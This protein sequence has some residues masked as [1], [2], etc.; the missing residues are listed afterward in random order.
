MLPRL[1]KIENKISDKLEEH[2]F[3]TENEVLKNKYKID[4]T[5]RKIKVHFYAKG[6]DKKFDEMKRKKVRF[7]EKIKEIFIE[8]VET[9]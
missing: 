2:K 9:N 5:K 4:K 1:Q 6:F 7:T 8:I 3:L